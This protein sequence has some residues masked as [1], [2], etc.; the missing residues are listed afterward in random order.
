NLDGRPQASEILAAADARSVALSPTPAFDGSLEDAQ[1]VFSPQHGAGVLTV[2]GLAPAP[3]DHTY[4]IWIIS[5]AR[6]HPAGLFQPGADG[7]AEVL[8]EGD[9]AA[10]VMV[11]ITVEPDGGS[12]APTGDVL[13]AARL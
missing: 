6:E 2:A 1:V 13:L 5:D 3:S 4:E 8:I 7:R 12:P 10:G 9:L 11:A